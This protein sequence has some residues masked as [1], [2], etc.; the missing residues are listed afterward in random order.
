[1]V[2]VAAAIIISAASPLWL[3]TGL[4]S[5]SVPLWK[6]RTALAQGVVA[7]RERLL[8]RDELETENARLR[9]ENARLTIRGAL[10]DELTAEVLRLESLLRRRP[11]ENAYV[12]AR[13]LASPNASP[14]DSFL[15]DAGA[16]DGITVGDYVVFDGTV[17]VGTIDAVTTDAA[18]ATLFSSPGL[19]HEVYIGTSSARV[20]AIGQGGGIFV[21]KTPKDLTIGPSDAVVLAGGIQAIA[22]VRSIEANESDA[23]QTV[24]AVMPVNL[25]EAREVFIRRGPPNAT[26]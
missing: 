2:L 23:F 26:P 20:Q 10:H 18:R 17:A 12:L 3:Q 6:I 22:F 25:F 13:V 21:I 14:Y 1:V 9:E 16:V 7:A 19:A 4:L 24:R 15:V 11:S 8:T 5:V